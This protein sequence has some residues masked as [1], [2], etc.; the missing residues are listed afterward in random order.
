MS[1]TLDTQSCPLENPRYPEQSSQQERGF[2]L[3]TQERPQ[4][5]H[6]RGNEQEQ[7][8]GSRGKELSRPRDRLRPPAG[9]CT[10]SL[11]RVNGEK[12]PRGWRGPCERA[13]GPHEL[14]LRVLG[15]RRGFHVFL[16]PAWSRKTPGSGLIT[17]LGA[18][19]G[20]APM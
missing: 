5:G 6:R 1:E 12:G 4:A 16:D 15:G 20:S 8:G 14:I 9:W 13:S 19:T 18:G 17:L 10:R 11:E 3:G 2:M 7:P